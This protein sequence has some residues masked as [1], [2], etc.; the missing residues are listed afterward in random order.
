MIRNDELLLTYKTPSLQ[1]INLEIPPSKSVA[2]R[3]IILANIFQGSVYLYDTPDCDDYEDLASALF[4]FQERGKDSLIEYKFRDGAAPFR[5]FLAYVASQPGSQCLITCSD[6][7]K[8]RPLSPLINVLRKAGARIECL[9]KEGFPPLKVFGNDLSWQGGDVGTNI[10]SQF[11]SALMM[12]SLVW[13]KPFELASHENVVSAPYVEMTR[14]MIEVFRQGAEFYR[15]L[16]PY[17]YNIEGDWSAASYFYEYALAE[18][19]RL[20]ILHNLVPPADS[21]QGDSVCPSIFG[22]LGVD[23]FFCE[24]GTVRIKADERRLAQLRASDSP[25]VLDMNDVP[26]LVP[27]VV[28]GLCMAGIKFVITGI[29]HLKYKESN[30]LDSLASELAKTGFDIVKKSGS[31]AWEG[32]R[33]DVNVPVCFDSHGDHRIAMAMA[34]MAVTFGEVSISGASCVNKS[35]PGFFDKLNCLGFV[36]KP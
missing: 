5:F 4:Q 10:S 18:P 32:K 3:A 24:D 36:G 19:S 6:R 22:M 28:A 29:E 7:L 20:L 33:L 11:V 1:E 35:F 17:E 13:N 21:V 25:V 15:E 12:A 14:K 31:L 23:T 26:D 16:G 27:A 34:V 9:E 30:R 2:L 8:Q